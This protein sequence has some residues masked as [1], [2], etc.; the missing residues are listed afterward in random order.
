MAQPFASEERICASICSSVRSGRNE[1]VPWV[2]LMASPLARD[3]RRDRDVRCVRR[4]EV[5]R[6]VLPHLE[7]GV[8]LRAALRGP[9]E[10]VG[11]LLEVVPALVP[12]LDDG[13]D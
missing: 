1:K 13:L 11:A 5:E 4:L 7:R 12:G 8:E 6:D 9:L 2:I 10:D 3:G